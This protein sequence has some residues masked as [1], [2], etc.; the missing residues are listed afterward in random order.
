MRKKIT[1]LKELEQEKEKLRMTMAITKDA[2]AQSI[3]TNRRQLKKIFI[4]NI[5]LPSSAIGLGAYAIKKATQ[6]KK[7][8]ISSAQQSTLFNGLL[9]QLLP[10]GIQFFQAYFSQAQQNELEATAPLSTSNSSK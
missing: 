7:I 5:L 2:L 4:G 8:P 1:S 3:G 6:T 9:K 10:I